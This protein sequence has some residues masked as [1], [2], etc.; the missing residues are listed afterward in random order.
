MP[1][2]VSEGDIDDQDAIIVKSQVALEW[3]VWIQGKAFL[4]WKNSSTS[5]SGHGSHAYVYAG[6]CTD[7][8]VGMD[9]GRHISMLEQTIYA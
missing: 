1:P 7:V 8:R 9:V 3:I 4:P 5:V 2:S 6:T